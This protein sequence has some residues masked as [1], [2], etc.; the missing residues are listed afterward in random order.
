VTLI[1]DRRLSSALGILTDEISTGSVVIPTD[2]SSSDRKVGPHCEMTWYGKQTVT[3]ENL[4][5]TFDDGNPVEKAIV[6]DDGNPAEKR[7]V[8]N[9]DNGNP[10][11]KEMATD[12]DGDPGEGRVT[13]DDG[14]LAEKW[15]A[16]DE[17]C[18]AGWA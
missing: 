12:D 13:F 15:G 11:E 10:G 2:E 16:S 14:S 4:R 6:V 17:L 7:S 18:F 8:T 3:F 9:N 5:A 1:S